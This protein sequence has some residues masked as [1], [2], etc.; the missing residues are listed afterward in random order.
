MRNRRINKAL[1]IR[2]LEAFIEPDMPFRQ[3]PKFTCHTGGIIF[4]TRPTPRLLIKK[5]R[6]RLHRDKFL[7]KKRKHRDSRRF[8]LSP[9]IVGVI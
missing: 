9:I 2:Q 1:S 4:Q 3:P 6:R 5:P 8:Q 7:P